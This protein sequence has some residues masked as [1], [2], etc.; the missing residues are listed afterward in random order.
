ALGRLGLEEAAGGL[1]ELV[2]LLVEREVHGVGPL[3][4][5]WI[6]P[7]SLPSPA[8]GP[9]TKRCTHVYAQHGDRLPEAAQGSPDPSKRG[10]G[11]PRPSAAAGPG[12]RAPSPRG[13]PHAGATDRTGR[14]TRRCGT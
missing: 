9:P 8:Q 4:R 5:G 11:P 14:D 1:A 6:G 12:P 10:R 2:L 3:G 13:A 7:R